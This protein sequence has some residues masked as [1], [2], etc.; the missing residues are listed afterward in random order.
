MNKSSLFTSVAL[1]T[2]LVASVGHAQTSPTA[3][4]IFDKMKNGIHVGHFNEF[5]N[6]K[7]L[8]KQ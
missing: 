5:P 4:A 8:D 2:F 3:L 6:N 7:N 1:I